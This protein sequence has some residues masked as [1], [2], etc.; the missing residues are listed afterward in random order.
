MGK[1][2]SKHSQ[3]EHEQI[4]KTECFQLARSLYNYA[5]EHFKVQIHPD[6]LDQPLILKSGH[7]LIFLPSKKYAYV[8]ITYS[9]IVKVS[10]DNGAYI[11]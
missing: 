3:E 2:Q 10:Y 6:N 7:V 1:S 4:K 11:S 8:Y 9:N 5:V